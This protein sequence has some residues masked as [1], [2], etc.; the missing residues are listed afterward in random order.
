MVRAPTS[1]VKAILELAGRDGFYPELREAA[2][3]TAT[4]AVV[5]LRGT[6]EETQYHL[7]TQA[8]ALHLARLFQKYGL[9]CLRK[10]EEALRRSLYPDEPFVSCKVNL[11]FQVGPWAHGLSKVAV[12]EA[13]VAIPWTAKVV[14]PCKGNSEGRFWVVGAADHPTTNV[15]QHGPQWVTISLLRDAP[16]ERPT[17]NVVASLKTI[18][19]LNDY[20]SAGPIDPWMQRD[21][22]QKDPWSSWKPASASA[23]SSTAPPT[24]LGDLEAAIRESVLKDVHAQVQAALPTPTDATMEVEPWRSQLESDIEEL[25]HQSSKF[26]DWFHEAGTKITALQDTIQQHGQ[27]IESL[28]TNVQQQAQVSVTLQQQIQSTGHTFGSFRR[29]LQFHTRAQNRRVRVLHGEYA[30]LRHNSSTCGAWTGVAFV[31]DLSTRE[32]KLPWSIQYTSGRAL[33]AHFGAVVY[34]PPSGPT[35]GATRGLADEFLQC[36]TEKIV[37]GSSGFRFIC[38]DWNRGPYDLHTFNLWRQAGWEEV[39]LLALQ[40]FH[41]PLTPTSKQAAYSD[42]IWVSPELAAHLTTV[43]LL[44]E[45]FSE[46]D[47]LLATFAVSASVALAYA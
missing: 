32:V 38:G 23:S 22:W 1:A 9:R 40:R 43:S 17:T 2:S 11:L 6:L 14:K 3:E 19:K 18:Q 35:Y 5:W 8:H 12:Q 13:I 36:L 25:R 44:E 47:P 28:T 41:R 27:S 37:F 15:F 4:Y 46:H 26:N 34:L 29:D 24:R 16:E 33:C 20:Q 21:P 42:Q 31:S 45:V 39:Q 30:P 7:R 10:N